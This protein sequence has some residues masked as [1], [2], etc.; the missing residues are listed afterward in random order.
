MTGATGICGGDVVVPKFSEFVPAVEV[1]EWP[2]K[3]KGSEC[4]SLMSQFRL[5]GADLV[6]HDFNDKGAADRF[7]ASA[8]NSARR[9]GG[10]AVRKRGTKVYLERVVDGVAG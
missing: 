2:R 7:A 8:R 1:E 10:I 3:K 6:V 5:S 9:I 4:D